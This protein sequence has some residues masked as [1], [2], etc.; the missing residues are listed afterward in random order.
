M[1]LVDKKGKNNQIG[2]I[3]E[4]IAAKLLEAKIRPTREP[5]I[6]SVLTTIDISSQF[7]RELFFAVNKQYKL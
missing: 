3:G 5:K 2:A 7:G 6:Q 4:E 1:K